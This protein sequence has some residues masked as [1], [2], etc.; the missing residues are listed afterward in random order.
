MVPHL[1]KDKNEFKKCDQYVVGIIL[2]PHV[3]IDHETEWDHPLWPLSRR[4]SLPLRHRNDPTCV[5]RNGEG[6]VL[7]KTGDTPNK[8]KIQTA[9]WFPITGEAL[10]FPTAS[11]ASWLRRPPRERKI[12]GS[13]PACAG[14]LALHKR[15]IKIGT[16][17]AALPRSVLGMV[18]PISVYCDWVGSK[19]C[20]ATSISV[21]Q[22][23]QLSEQIRP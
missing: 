9:P 15:A 8:L 19:V 18:G 14:I 1:S 3:D 11:L 16:P 2:F 7:L 13:N 5:K 20:S 22:H 6:R 4:T 23:V 21:W 17:A 10:D 12:P